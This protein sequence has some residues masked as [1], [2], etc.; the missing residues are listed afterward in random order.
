MKSKIFKVKVSLE[1]VRQE[2]LK[3]DREFFALAKAAGAN[4]AYF[5]F[6]TGDARLHRNGRLPVVGAKAAK[7]FL[8]EKNFSM[9]GE[10]I[11]SDV[12]ESD[13]FGY[14][15]GSYELK[16]ADSQESEK[17]YYVRTWKR[18]GQGSWKIVLDVTNPLPK[19]QS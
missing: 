6:V 19:K 5:S 17:G 16:Y 3:V 4:K 11:Q 12:A 1:L 13:D 9:T 18:D 2:L 15:Y 8:A 14:T 10:P 7:A